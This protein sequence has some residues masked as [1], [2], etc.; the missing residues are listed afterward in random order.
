[1]ARYDSARKIRRN[2]LIV[3][4]RKAHPADSL[5]EIADLF[6]VSRQRID[7]IIRR[8]GDKKIEAIRS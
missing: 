3:E 2:Q 7:F 4:Y 1:M 5:Q 6:G 8:D